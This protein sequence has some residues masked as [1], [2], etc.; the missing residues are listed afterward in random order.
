MSREDWGQGF[1]LRRLGIIGLIH[2]GENKYLYHVALVREE[3]RVVW[4]LKTLV[5]P[6]VIFIENIEGVDLVQVWD[7]NVASRKDLSLCILP[8]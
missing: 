8:C 3:V 1:V 2:I 6:N 5:I 7:T 4:H